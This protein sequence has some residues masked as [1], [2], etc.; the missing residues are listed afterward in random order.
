VQHCKDRDAADAHDSGTKKP[1]TMGSQI[2]VDEETGQ[3]VDV[4]DSVPAPTADM[5]V[6]EQSGLLERLPSGV[7][8]IGDLAYVGIAELHPKGLGATPRRKPRGKA[9]PLEDMCFNRAFAKRRIKVEHTIGR[10][11]R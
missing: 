4:A 1:H 5:T 8:G 3:S 9:R 2:A 11:R 10:M 7:G 6:L